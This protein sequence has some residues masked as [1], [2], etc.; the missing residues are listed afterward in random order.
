MKAKLLPPESTHGLA[1]K[2]CTS[3]VYDLFIKLSL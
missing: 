1:V 3:V 2:K